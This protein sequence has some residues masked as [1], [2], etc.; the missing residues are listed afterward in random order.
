MGNVASYFRSSSP[1]QPQRKDRL[2]AHLAKLNVYDTKIFLLNLL[3]NDPTARARCILLN[4]STCGNEKSTSALTDEDIENLYIDVE[5]AICECEAEEICLEAF[6]DLVVNRVEEEGGRGM[7]ATLHRMLWLAWGMNRG[8]SCFLH[9][10]P[11]SLPPIHIQERFIRAI[12]E[13]DAIGKRCGYVWAL[14]EQGKYHLGVLIIKD[15]LYNRVR[16]MKD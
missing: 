3:N 15:H 2:I 10:D 14:N 9:S 6:I 4:D 13:L 7:A 8:K 1:I 11:Q 5:F 12:E 16:H